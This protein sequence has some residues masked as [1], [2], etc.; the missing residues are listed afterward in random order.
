M[1]AL[2]AANPNDGT[3]LGTSEII[4]DEYIDPVLG[5]RVVNT[6]PATPYKMPRSKIAVGPYGQDWGD[7]SG[8]IPL[9]VEQ[10]SLRW[11][12][13]QQMMLARLAARE[14]LQKWAGET[15]QLV[16]SRGMHLNHRGVR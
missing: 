7:A 4:T 12:M 16:D 11:A 1:P 2:N 10:R 9:Q 5:C 8:D 13:E 14:S 3:V 15:D 6:L